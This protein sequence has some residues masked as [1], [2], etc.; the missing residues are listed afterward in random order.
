VG[1]FEAN[2]TIAAIATAHGSAPRGV[3]RLSGPEAL[4]IALIGFYGDGRQPIVPG[5]AIRS[6]Q[7]SVAGL[8]PRLPVTL[9]LWPGSHT[10]T[11][12]PLAE[13]HTVGSPPLLGL[14]LADCLARGAR[15]AEPGEFTLRAFLSGRLDLTR[16]EAVLGVI[17]A[18]TTGQLEAALQQLAGGLSG[19]I[20]ELRERLLDLLAHLE[21][22]LDFVDE[23]DVDPVVRAV[24]S[25]ELSA[26]ATQLQSLASTL[27]DRDRPSAMARV[28]LVGPPNAGKSRLFN[29]LLEE[30]RAIVSPVPGTTTDYLSATCLCDGL[31]VEVVDTAGFEPAAGPISSEAQARRDEQARLADLVLDCVPADSPEAPRWA[32]PRPHVR[33]ATKCDLAAPGPGSIATSAATGM[34]LDELRR[35]IATALVAR[36]QESDPLA[37]TGAR[38]RESL[39]RAEKALRSA[40]NVL[41]LGG[42]D[43]LVALDLR[44]ALDELGKV[45]GAV[46][47]E[48]ILDRIFRKF[49][50]GK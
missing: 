36:D 49:C 40:A 19:P 50:I 2:D 15:L 34:G 28:V 37:A 38:C 46:V 35:A 29:A 45:V 7:R 6:G 32:S 16:A 4:E 11:G 27:R 1:S 20:G 33:V 44:Q 14:L 47:T 48:D 39:V 13:I 26:A 30:G 23:E 31:V 25:S 9:A 42:D 3:V 22:G 18:R 43:E 10:Y 8:R 5:P 24:L 21:A 41:A 17:E 12:Q